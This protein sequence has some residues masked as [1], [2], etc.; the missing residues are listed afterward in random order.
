[1]GGGHGMLTG[2]GSVRVQGLPSKP[3]EGGGALAEGVNGPAGRAGH[4]PHSCPASRRRPPSALPRPSPPLLLGTLARGP[5][6]PG[7]AEH[8]AGLR[9]LGFVL[10]SCCPGPRPQARGQLFFLNRLLWCV[11]LSPH[12]HCYS[13]K[14]LS[15]PTR[16]S[17]P[18]GGV[19]GPSPHP[20]VVK[21]MVINPGALSLLFGVN[22]LAA[23][24]LK[25]R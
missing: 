15:P 1:M 2:V 20:G 19:R 16:S 21:V 7:T 23:F 9:V 4:T 8:L 17:C 18:P 12:Y 11:C 22:W 14:M 25:E 3:L 24:G 5:S 13:F 10:A 6:A